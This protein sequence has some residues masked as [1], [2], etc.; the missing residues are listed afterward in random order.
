[1]N[2]PAGP[3]AVDRGSAA[4]PSLLILSFSPIADDARVLKQVALFS[5]RY[6]VTTCGY[7]PAPAGVVAH[8]EVPAD[9]P[10]WRKDPR[11]LLARQYR[12]V[13]WGNAA[14]AHARSVLPVGAFDVI[15]A[16]DVDPV[17]LALSLAPRSGVHADLHEYAPGQNS[18][19]PR[20]RWFVA[21][22][23]RWI[24]RR[25]VTRAASVTTV[26]QGIADRYSRELGVPVGVVTNA[27]PYAELD[28]QPVGSPIRLVHSGNAQR[29]RTLEVMIDGVEQSAADVTLDLLLMPNDPV[30]LAEL[31]ARCAGSTRVRVLDPVPYA[32]LVR[33]LNGYDVGVFVLPP[34]NYNYE[35][36]L[37]NKFFD[38]VQARLGVIV[39][40]SPE[41][42]REVETR[43]LG[44]VTQDF[45][46]G[47][48]AAVLDALDPAQVATWKRESAACARELS[49]EVQSAGWARAVDRIAGEAQT[50]PS[51]DRHAR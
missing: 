7:G 35:W 20:W 32:D 37:P 2:A 10:A 26:G 33:T 24:C 21:P 38:Y 4:R 29:N 25:F 16:D 12:R 47:A 41:M 46:S 34:V 28:A 49:A 11:W 43:G 13:Y 3:Q 30:Y 51:K 48:F 36:T 40:P 19:L 14:V 1:M 31:R 5:G 44:A 17:P 8:V 22:Y 18:E 6:D 27:A 39:G 50:R 15:L 42:A 9:L 45:T 23:I